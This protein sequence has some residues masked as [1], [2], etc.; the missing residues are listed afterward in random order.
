M[1]EKVAIT[2]TK[3]DLLA[4]TINAKAGTSG[5]KTI[6]QMVEAV[7]T[8]SSGSGIKIKSMRRTSGPKKTAYQSGETFSAQG[9]LVELT[10]SNYAIKS[11]MRVTQSLGFSWDEDKVLLSGQTSF[12]IY[13][14]EDG[15]TISLDIPISVSG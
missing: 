12:T 8:L 3:L 1:A 4:D 5:K 2:K 6:D 14:T 9:L 13:Y 10:Y 15:T 11:S 7:Q